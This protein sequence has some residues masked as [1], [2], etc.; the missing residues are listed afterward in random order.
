MLTSGMANAVGVPA[1]AVLA[2]RFTNLGSVF[3][4]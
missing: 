4:P 2:A 3:L 1:D